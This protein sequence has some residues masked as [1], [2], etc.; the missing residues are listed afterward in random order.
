MQKICSVKKSK[1]KSTD[2]KTCH[3][4]FQENVWHVY[5]GYVEIILYSSARIFFRVSEMFFIRLK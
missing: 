5:S 2:K 3:K 1:S 4:F